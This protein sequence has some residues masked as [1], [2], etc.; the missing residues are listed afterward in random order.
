MIV[1]DDYT[2]SSRLVLP[3]WCQLTWVVQDKIPEARKMVVCVC[4]CVCVCVLLSQLLKSSNVLQHLQL[5]KNILYICD[6]RGKLYTA[7]LTIT[8]S[9]A[10]YLRM[11]CAISSTVY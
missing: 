3:S 4:V 10:T 9:F 1:Y 11:M 5:V 8:C 2:S 6:S 7:L